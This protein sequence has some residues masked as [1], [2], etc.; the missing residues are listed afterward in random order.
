MNT[1]QNDNDCR[2]IF[3]L[4]SADDKLNIM[5]DELVSIRRTQE[6]TNQGMLAFQNSFRYMSE[7]INQVIQATNKNTDLLKTLAYKSIDQE[8]RSRRNNLIFW[9][10]QKTIMKIVLV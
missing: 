7:S 2:F 5:F 9:N 3:M 4:S 6:Q 10:W 1:G 8:A